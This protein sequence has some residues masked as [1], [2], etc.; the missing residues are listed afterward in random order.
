M[1]NVIKILAIIASLPLLVLGAKAMFFPTSMFEMFDLKPQGTFGMNTIRADLGGM[2]IASALMIYVGLWKK[3][4][5]WF[6]ATILIMSTLLVG[7][8]IS[9]VSDGWTNAAIP[10]VAVEVFVISVLSLAHNNFGSAKE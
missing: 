4:T 10:A 8:A 6:L 3:N 1:K 9:F 2:L 5:T 7:R